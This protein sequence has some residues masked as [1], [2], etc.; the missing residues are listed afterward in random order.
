VGPRGGGGG[1]GGGVGV[2]WG[3]GGGGG[4]VSSWKLGEGVVLGL[5]NVNPNTTPSPCFGLTSG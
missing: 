3:G 2:E 5:G 4:G 1:G